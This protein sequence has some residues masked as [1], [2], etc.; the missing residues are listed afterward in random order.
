[1]ADTDRDFIYELASLTQEEV[2]CVES[3]IQE[4][5]D[6]QFIESS[7]YEKLLEYYADEMPYLV[8]K[9]RCEC[10]PDVWILERLGT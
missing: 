1:M 4:D 2:D 6:G 5:N 3:Y 10:E 8:Q 7:A 9:A